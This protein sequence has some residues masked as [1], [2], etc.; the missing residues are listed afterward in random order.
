MPYAG[1]LDVYRV[2]CAEVAANDYEGFTLSV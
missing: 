1:G 2:K